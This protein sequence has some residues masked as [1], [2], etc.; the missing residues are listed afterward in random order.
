MAGKGR[1]KGAVSWDPASDDLMMTIV[2]NKLLRGA[3]GWHEVCVE[4]NEQR[5]ATMVSLFFLSFA[6]A[7]MSPQAER[8]EEALRSRFKKRLHMKQSSGNPAMPPLTKRALDAMRAIENTL[9]A[10]VIS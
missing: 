3:N 7:V 2:E 4:F 10:G 9:S 8:N 6:L 5:R 1:K